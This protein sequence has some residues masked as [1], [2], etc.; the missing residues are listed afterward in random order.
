MAYAIQRQNVVSEIKAY[1]INTV[2]CKDT[3]KTNKFGC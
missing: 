1:L 3:D 2:S